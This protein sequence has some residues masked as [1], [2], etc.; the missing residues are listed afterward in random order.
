MFEID[1]VNGTS[2]GAIVG[3]FAC[4]G[5]LGDLEAIYRN[6]KSK[7]DFLQPWYDIPLIGY[8][9]SLMYAVVRKKGFF[10]KDKII[11]TFISAFKP[12][13]KRQGAIGM[14]KYN[15]VVVDIDANLHKYVNGT[16]KNIKR[17]IV[18]SAS[19]PFAFEPE[20][21]D[22]RYYC[23]GGIFE[24]YPIGSNKTNIDVEDYKG[25]DTSKYYLIIDLQLY[26]SDKKGEPVKYVDKDINVG[27][28]MI[29][30]LI[31]LMSIMSEQMAYHDIH[32]YDIF[33]N[34]NVYYIPYPARDSN[35]CRE[36]FDMC[37]EKIAYTIKAGEIAANKFIEEKCKK[38]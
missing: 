37:P 7:N 10:C 29:E 11:N 34:D 14:D 35:I 2:G 28:N 23:D 15:C 36:T 27:K 12:E 3:A 32:Q 9:A 38:N 21:I 1:S 4:S 16:S 25:L 17:Y 30:Y 6:I 18:G 22:G 8:Y 33:D 5:Q 13:I 19:L 24:L 31:T 26:E 20:E